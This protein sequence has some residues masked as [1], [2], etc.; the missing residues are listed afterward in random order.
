MPKITTDDC[1]KFLVTMVPSQILPATSWAFDED[2]G[3]DEFMN[4]FTD[5]AGGWEKAKHLPQPDFDDP[6]NIAK[7]AAYQEANRIKVEAALLEPKNWKRRSKTK[8]E[9]NIA[10]VREFMC[11]TP[12]NLFDGQVGYR[13]LE[14]RDGT[15]VL[16]DYIGD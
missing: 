9:D 6:A 14:R 16:G 4:N 15:L 11:E 3:W 8:G 1:R 5:E 13:V 2:S 7:A 10:V 12:D